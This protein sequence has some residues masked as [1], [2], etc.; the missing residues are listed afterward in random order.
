MEKCCMYVPS[1]LPTESAKELSLKKQCSFLLNVSLGF[2]LNDIRSNHWLTTQ[3]FNSQMFGHFAVLIQKDKKVT[4]TSSGLYEKASTTGD[5]LEW[6]HPNTWSFPQIAAPRNKESV[7]WTCTSLCMITANCWRAAA[8]G[9][10]LNT[11]CW[12]TSVV[13]WVLPGTVGASTFF[14]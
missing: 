11:G 7:G 2:L 13:S 4:G 1:L 10:A 5:L 8:C 9:K 6:E 14:A 3:V 12:S